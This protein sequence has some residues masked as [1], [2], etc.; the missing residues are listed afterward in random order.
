LHEH[1]T[2][3]PQDA[4]E[5]FEYRRSG[6]DVTAFEGLAASGLDAVFDNMMDGTALITS[7]NGWKWDDIIYDLGMRQCD[8]AHQD[9]VVWA[10]SVDDILRAKHHGQVAWIPALEDSAPTENEL[11]RIEILY[12]LGVRMMG[13]VYSEANAL[14]SGH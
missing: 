8:I 10:G 13:I 6:R 4:R 5:I 12:G 3:V 11:D 2:V 9:F 1:A 14:A 7:H